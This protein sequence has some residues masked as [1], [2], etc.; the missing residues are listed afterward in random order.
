MESDKM[1]DE[2]QCISDNPKFSVII[3]AYNSAA[4]LAKAVE[5]VIEQTWSAHEIIVIDDG[6]TDNTLQVARE[7]GDKIRIIHQYNAGVSVARN[8]GVDVATGDWLAFLDADDWYYPDRLRLHAEWIANDPDL[9]FLTGDYEYRR[10]D[11]SVIGTSMAKHASGRTMLEMA[12]GA[13][14]VVIGEKQKETFV[15]DHF[16]DTHTLSVPRETFL[17]LGGYPGG[18]SVCEDVHLL[19]RLCA[20]SRRIGVVCLPMAVYIIHDTSA[21]RADPLKA[22]QYNVQT[23]LDLKRIAH[24]FPKPV[25]RGI[26]MRLRNGRLNLAYA[27]VRAGRRREAISAVLPSL[28]EAPGWASLYNLAT[29]L[30]G[31]I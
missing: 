4:T 9:D 29:I 12:E 10:E 15:A 27:L 31:E 26:M 1:K 19:I 8:R 17:R 13:E 25:K 18:F 21:T 5:S 20:V 2:Q 7:F 30:K 16:G 23:L 14:R 28:V 3:P 22:Q 6:S 11:D 24:N